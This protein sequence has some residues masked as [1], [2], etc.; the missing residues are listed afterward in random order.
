MNNYAI[1][2]GALR[3]YI[4]GY[5]GL[6]R[7][8]LWAGS[9]LPPRLARVHLAW[10]EPRTT[11]CFGPPGPCPSLPPST[12]HASL[13][14]PGPLTPLFSTHPT[15]AS[16]LCIH[17][18]ST[19]RASLGLGAQHLVEDAHP[20][21]LGLPIHPNTPMRAVS[22]PAQPQ[23]EPGGVLMHLC[24]SAL[25][26]G[27]GEALALD[28]ELECRDALRVPRH[29]PSKPPALIPVPGPTPPPSG[30]C[31][32]PR[33]SYATPQG[34]GSLVQAWSM[35]AVRTWSLLPC[36][37]PTRATVRAALLL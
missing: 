24:E 27:G 19:G 32:G 20:A 36:I 1:F 31:L 7:C 34:V 15:H 14:H 8:G 6:A 11:R 30:G 9:S 37:K 23:A 25:E 18:P 13:C 5:R 29:L 2:G 28:V 17:P 12:S 26:E 10:R 22:S 35:P 3:V 33:P 16:L 21:L 4:R